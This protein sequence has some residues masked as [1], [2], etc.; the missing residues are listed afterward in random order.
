MVARLKDK[1]GTSTAERH[2]KNYVKSRIG[3]KLILAV[4]FENLKAGNE[5]II[6]DV[7][8]DGKSYSS[9]VTL[10]DQEF[11]IPNSKF[12]KPLIGR[13]GK[14]ATSVEE[15]YLNCLNLNI[16]LAKAHNAC[17]YVTIDTTHGLMEIEK[18]E[19]I[20]GTPKADFVLLAP[21][22]YSSLFI[23]H[24][25]GTT[26]NDFQQFGGVSKFANNEMVMSFGNNLKQDYPEGI[27][28]ITVASLLNVNQ[29]ISHYELAV[30]SMYGHEFGSDFSKDNV[31][32]IRQGELQLIRSTGNTYTLSSVHVF[33][34]GEVPDNLKLMIYAR[35]S[36][37]RNDLGIK[38]TRVLVGP[39]N[40]R[41]VDRYY[42]I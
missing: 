20:N 35:G 3:E 30:K 14:V 39:N 21:N 38:N 13:V 34:N 5:L 23:S 10:D 7:V 2:A 11:L 12:Y 8:D 29:K 26:M 6:K 41:K 28:K 17:T 33:T 25:A 40:G 1:S 16:E 24:K 36:S 27:S 22:G 42:E 37:D 32:E 15:I 19:K 4:D 31:H 18:A 9:L